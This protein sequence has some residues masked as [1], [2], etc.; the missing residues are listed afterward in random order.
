MTQFLEMSGKCLIIHIFPAWLQN[1]I[2][3]AGL[4]A[5]LSH[6]EKSCIISYYRQFSTKIKNKIHKINTSFVN[7]GLRLLGAN[8]TGFNSI[9]FFILISAESYCHA[10][11]DYYTFKNKS[12]YENKTFQK[13]IVLI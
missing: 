12:Q 11:N 6:T 5:V 9:E 10:I 7:M 3:S 4:E 2:I 1:R 8:K 13:K